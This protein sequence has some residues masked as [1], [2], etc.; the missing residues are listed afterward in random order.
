[1]SYMNTPFMAIFGG[2]KETA[3]NII[4]IL[5]HKGK[6]Y[7]NKPVEISGEVRYKLI[8]ISNQ[9][10]PIP[11]GIKDGLVERLAGTSSQKNLKGLMISQI[12]AQTTKI[13]AKIIATRLTPTS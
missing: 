4:V 10:D 6:F 13:V 7:F 9:G 8:G 12:Q 2:T 1:M 5:Y 3:V 11:I